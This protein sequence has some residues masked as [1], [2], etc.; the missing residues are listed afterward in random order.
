MVQVRE[1]KVDS[2]LFPQNI[3]GLPQ[4]YISSVTS[5]TGTLRLIVHRMGPHAHMHRDTQVEGFR[6]A[7]YIQWFPPFCPKV[8]AIRVIKESQ[9][10][11]NIGIQEN[12]LW[13]SSL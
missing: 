4:A 13:P 3:P 8:V 10:G 12:A 2:A 5:L 1:S 7:E 11:T 6:S 9:R